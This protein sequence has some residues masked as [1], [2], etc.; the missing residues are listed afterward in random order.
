MAPF[1]PDL[2]CGFCFVNPLEEFQHPEK[3]RRSFRLQIRHDFLC[4]IGLES[5]DIMLDIFGTG[6]QVQVILQDNISEYFEGA[7]LL[8][9]FP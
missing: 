2:I 9:I 4:S 7:V 3:T 1:L 5:F 6:N 8:K